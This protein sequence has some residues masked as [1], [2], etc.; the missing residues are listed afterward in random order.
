MKYFK[1]HDDVMAYEDD[2]SQDDLIPIGATPLNESEALALVSQPLTADQI[3]ANKTGVVQKL[4]DDQARA[5]GY[6]SINI[7]ITFA[8]EP[9]VPKFQKEGQALRAWRSRVWEKANELLS[10]MDDE[11]VS[12]P[13]DSELLHQ[14][15]KFSLGE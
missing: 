15:P 8:D 5:L 1:Y 13:T 3:K 9:A 14:M 11:S 12:I 2:G 7:A 4:L 6:E 10:L